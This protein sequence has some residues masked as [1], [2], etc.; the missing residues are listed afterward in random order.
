[1]Y[2]KHLIA[3]AL[4]TLG[5]TASALEITCEQALSGAETTKLPR[6]DYAR[7]ELSDAL[8]CAWSVQGDSPSSAQGPSLTPSVLF[9]APVS[10][11]P[12]EIEI[13]TWLNVGETTATQV[14]LLDKNLQPIQWIPFA[15]YRERKS[16]LTARF[17]INPGDETHFIL[18]GGAA[19][20][21][22]STLTRTYSPLSS[23]VLRFAGVNTA[24]EVST[25]FNLVPR[26]KIRV[27][28]R[29]SRSRKI[30][31]TR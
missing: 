28:I 15:A 18:V 22:E 7:F 31:V 4:L 12:V 16:Y 25:E 11:S 1:M 10:E 8:S 13:G 27:R 24:R 29:K 5:G 3:M 23:N 6:K 30:N 21:T 14:A 9:K 17:F 2:A 26:G 20:A 19:S